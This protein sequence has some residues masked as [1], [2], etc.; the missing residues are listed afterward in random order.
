MP[1]PKSVLLHVCCGPCAITPVQWL[2]N[3]GYE[4]TGFFYNPNIHP[5][6]EYVRRRDG[7]LKVAG[8]LDFPVLIQDDAYKPEKWLQ[9]VC[10]QK[11]SRCTFCYTMRLHAVAWTAQELGIHFFSTTLFYSK[12]QNHDE[13]VT[14]GQSVEQATGTAFF[15]ED[16]RIGWKEGIKLSKAWG[17]Y[18]QQYCGCLYS[19]NER[20]AHLLGQ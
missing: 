6:T 15:Y 16:F 8:K 11:K 5:L 19:E 7:L 4:V 18:R 2:L 17:I 9:G 14:L 13:L 3:K 12:F 1:Q 20:Y 10:G